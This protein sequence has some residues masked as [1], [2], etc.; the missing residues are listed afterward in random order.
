MDETGRHV[1]WLTLGLAGFVLL[2]ACANLANLQIAR[3]AARARDFAVRAALG[4]SRAQL[5]RQLLVESV[6]VA[7][8]GGALGVLLAVWLDD[9]LSRQFDVAGQ[10]AAIPLDW[11]VLGFALAVSFA[12]GLLAGAVPAWLASRTDVNSSLKQQSRGATGDRS[13]HRLRNS[14]IVAE[15]AF[16]LVL[17][18]GASFFI[19]GLQRFA[20]RDPGWRTAGLLTGSLTLPDTLPGDKYVKEDTRRAFYD[21][22]LQR[23]TALPG[24]EHASLSSSL[25]IHSFNS[26]SNFAVEGRADAPPGREPLADYV[27]VTADFFDTL[28]LQLVAGSLFPDNLRP[29]SPRVAIINETMARQFWPGANP[30]GKRI[31]SPDPKARDWVEVI[32]VVRD[33]GFVASLGVPDTR[34]QVY[35]PLVQQAWGYLAVA[36]RAS[37]PETLAEPLRRA[38]AE[39]DPDLPVA[40]I[41]TI[42]QAVDHAQHNFHVANQLLAGF[43]AL[44]LVLA[45]VGLYGV[46]STLVV[47][48]TQEFGI[49]LALGAQGRDVLRLVLGKCLWLAALGVGLGLVGAAV[50]VRLLSRV[51]PGLPAED[52]LGLAAVVLLLVAVMFLACWIPARR[53]TRI[54]PL[55]ALRA[56]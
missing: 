33:V 18:A 28:G 35:R 26:S 38:V 50:L 41:R 7:L 39:L 53:A 10:H 32:G 6:T 23:L 43:A 11:S 49:R 42:G 14:L 29:D 19:R 37:N 40:D 16:A 5:I 27:Y 44:G 47:Q 31:G 46:I 12:A 20:A 30:V 36:L 21:R 1:A 45:A 34:L 55:V 4:A 8:A 51:V 24:V 2:I 9:L 15:L 52:P 3:S 54:D 17:L 48:R 13:R 22:L 56:E 25:P